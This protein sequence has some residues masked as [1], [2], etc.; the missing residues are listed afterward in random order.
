MHLIELCAPN[1]A[2]TS[3]PGVGSLSRSYSLAELAL[4][5]PHAD[6]VL[7]HHKAP[8]LPELLF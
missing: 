4:A 7:V 8:E 3:W 2:P 5:L 1:V 6:C